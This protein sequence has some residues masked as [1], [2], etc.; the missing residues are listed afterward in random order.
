VKTG[1]LW[2]LDIP[3][4]DTKNRRPLD[5]P[6]PA[7]LSARIDLYLERFRS[8]IP[9]TERHT[10]VWASNQGRPMCAMAI[11]IA[12]RKRT[13]KAFGFAVNLHRFRHAAASFW[14]IQDPAN[15]RG[16]KDLLGQA[17]FGITEKHYIMAQS[18][19]AGRVLARAVDAARK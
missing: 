3:A 13:K 12:V 18:R 7:E 1:D 11:S 14:S 10:S 8:R 15:V 2:G 4:A 5:Y 19:V 9:G 16:A 17:S 6:I